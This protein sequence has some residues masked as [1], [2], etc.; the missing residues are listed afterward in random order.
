MPRKTANPN[1]PVYRAVI[2]KQ[3]PGQEPFTTYEGPYDTPGA[4]QGRVTFWVNY[5][6][7]SDDDG[8]SSGSRASGC[9][10]IGHTTWSGYC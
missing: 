5:L 7:D 2:V 1:A 6:T 10:E 8:V 4:A 3:Y 9:V